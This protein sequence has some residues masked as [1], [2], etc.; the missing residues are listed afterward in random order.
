MPQQTLSLAQA[1]Q[2]KQTMAMSPMQR[3]SLDILQ[4]PLMALEQKIREEAE[5]NPAIDE[6]IVPKIELDA[7]T[8]DRDGTEAEERASENDDDFQMHDSIQR[9][10]QD[11][12]AEERRRYMFESIRQPVSLEQH[13]RSQ[14]QTAG[15]SPEE[16]AVADTI[17]ANLSSTGMLAVSTG[18]IAE[19]TGCRQQTVDGVLAKIQH[20]FDPPGIAARSASERIVLQLDATGDPRA[21][22]A[23]RI[24]AEHIDDLAAGHREAVIAA[25]LGVPRAD[26]EDAIALIKSLAPNPVAEFDTVAPTDYVIPEIEVVRDESGKWIAQ[27]D[28]DTAAHVSINEDLRAYLS[29]NSVSG[30]DK[31][32]IREHLRNA[33]ALAH[34]LEQRSETIFK[35]G[36]AIVEMQQDFFTYGVSRMKPMTLADVAARIGRHETTVSRAAEGKYMRTPRGIFELKYFFSAGLRTNGGEGAVVSNK[37]VMD[38]IVSIIKGEDPRRPLSDQE[39]MGRLLKMGIEIKRRT[40]AKY[41]DILHIP[42][43]SQRRRV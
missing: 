15:F 43:S 27:Y 39:I 21:A 34:S 38:K 11:P 14:I 17:V 24:A 26:V 2:Q 25:D 42:P 4:L 9:L 31:S 36:Q 5:S 3:Q 22:V 20:G 28:A 30:E 29:D 13:L 40:I 6:I 33:E 19:V 1:Q 32:Y 12:D 41:R 37:A 18:E 16:E 8:V 23:R 7:P 35:V 10:S